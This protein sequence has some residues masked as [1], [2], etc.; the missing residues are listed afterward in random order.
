MRMTTLL[1]WLVVTVTAGLA[2]SRPFGTE[3]KNAV[4]TTDFVYG[5]EVR[6]TDSITGKAPFQATLMAVGGG[7]HDSIGPLS[8]GANASVL[9]F[10][11]AGERRGTYSLLVA[12]PGGYRDWT[13]NGVEVTGGQCHVNT[14]T[15]DARLQRY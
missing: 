14:V 4:C 7:G 9:V 13:R 6:V 12:S 1:L 15:I 8:A 3:P 10:L 2:C 11:A 5:L